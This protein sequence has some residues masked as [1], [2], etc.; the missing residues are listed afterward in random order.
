MSDELGS[1][2]RMSDAEKRDF[3]REV[4]HPPMTRET[5]RLRI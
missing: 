1:Y 5:K 4:Q 3:M 2:E